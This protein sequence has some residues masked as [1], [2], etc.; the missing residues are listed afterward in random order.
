[1]ILTIIALAVTLVVMTVRNRPRSSSGQETELVRKES[2]TG[3]ESFLDPSQDVVQKIRIPDEY[4]RL[5]DRQWRPFRPVYERWTQ[6]MTEPYWIDPEELVQEEL[7]KQSDLEIARFFE[8][9]P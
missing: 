4:T 9:V 1:A 3:M 7:E 8:D 6:E 5:Y 2:S